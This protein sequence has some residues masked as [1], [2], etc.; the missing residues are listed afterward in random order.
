[1]PAVEQAL[2]QSRGRRLLGFLASFV[3]VFA[4]LAL[5]RGQESWFVRAHV[6]I[7]NA[8]L[9]ASPRSGFALQF[10]PSPSEAWQAILRVQSLASGPS[11]EIPIDLRMLVY[12]PLSAFVA[13]VIASPLGSAR[14]HLRVLIPG[15]LVLEPLLLLLVALPLLSFLGGTGPVQVLT[16]SRPTLV[17]LQLLYRALV[18][19]LGMTYAL[20]LL[21]WWILLGRQS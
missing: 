15:L 12:L 13:L 3:A 2:P 4:G 14:A 1:M 17:I 6:A 8:L 20:P 11:I 16:L 5:L 19:P 21:L 18:A 10:L 7:A 9:P